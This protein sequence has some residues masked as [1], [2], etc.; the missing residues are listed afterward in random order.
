MGRV[1]RRLNAV[2]TDFAHLTFYGFLSAN[3][4]ETF[5]IAQDGNQYIGLKQH[6]NDYSFI[7]YE[8]CNKD[9]EAMIRGLESKG[10]HVSR[11]IQSADVENEFPRNSFNNT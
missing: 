11:S 2:L 3:G 1:I 5:V 9:M 6:N 4:T 7:C 8:V 10:I